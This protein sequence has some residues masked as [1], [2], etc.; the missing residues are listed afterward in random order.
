MSAELHPKRSGVL[1]LSVLA[2]T[3]K[4][5]LLLIGVVWLLVLGSQRLGYNWQWYRIPQY[6]WH[7]SDQGFT[8]GPLME[9][10]WVTFKITGISLAL[11]LVIG[12]ATA[13]MRM[14]SSWAARG[15]ARGYMEMIRN[16]PLLIQIFFI[17]FVIAPILDISAFNSA[18]S[19]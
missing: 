8:W 11:M 9:G 16:T 18:S 17:Y 3:S 2:D 5:L 4:T 6:L 13:L 15:V 19:P 12:L 1:S 7:V 14:S 10:L